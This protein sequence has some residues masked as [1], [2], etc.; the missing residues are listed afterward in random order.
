M[1]N[2]ENK[3]K[4]KKLILL[5]LLFILTVVIII[6]LYRHINK[7][8]IDSMS[9]SSIESSS[10]IVKSLDENGDAIDGAVKS[11]TEDIKNELKKKQVS[12]TDK[13]SSGIQFSSSIKGSTGDWT[14]ENIKTNSVIMQG[15]VY[16][17]KKLIIKTV[18]LKPDQYINT[19]TLLEDV[20]PGQ[21]KAVAYIN[22]YD[23]KTKEYISRAGFNVTLVVN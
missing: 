6:F 3:Q 22:Y 7:P 12:V 15:E 2:K 16:I 14:V 5:L 13:L 20:Q 8:D 18:P 4:K 11:K 19:V 23:L 1:E 21:Y 10:E 17:E 9:T